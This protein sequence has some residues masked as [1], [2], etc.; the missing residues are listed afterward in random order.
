[1]ADDQKGFGP[2]VADDTA[3]F[4]APVE[5]S[6]LTR[7]GTNPAG[8]PVYHGT[9]TA[10]PTFGSR[11]AESLGVPTSTDDLKNAAISTGMGILYPPLLA[12]QAAQQMWNKTTQPMTP[13]EKADMAVHPVGQVLNQGAKRILEGPLAPVG[14]QVVSNIAE[15]KGNLGAQAGDVVGTIANLLM[16][17]EA[18][19]PKTEGRLAYSTGA[20]A[21]DIMKAAPDL[22]AEASKNGR[23]ADLNGLIEGTIK[24]AKD[25]LNT[26]YANALGPYANQKIM[27]SQVSQRILALITPNMDMTQPGK[28]LKKQIQSAAVEFQKPWTLAQLDQERM[29]ANA[30]L[31]S[32]EKKEAVDQYAATRGNNRTA[33]IDKAIA[34][35]VRADVY[36]LMDQAL[37]KPPGYFANIKDRIGA[38][39]DI[40]S[41]AKAHRDALRTRSLKAEGAPMMERLKLRGLVG[42]EGH[43]RFYFSNLLGPSDPLASAG[44][45]AQAAFPGPGTS[46]ARAA[47]LVEALRRF[48][49]NHPLVQNNEPQQ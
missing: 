45:I 24:N 27:P 3:G 28:V 1:M 41:D 19:G 20:E 35:G 48:A 18:K 47:A 15:D 49:P 42:E 38:L 6:S 23:P 33:A 26:E 36:P 5:D 43:P 25:N 8:F 4:G 2:P 34:D 32:F 44:K 30:R 9:P 22:I 7:V 12:G 14:G 21:R 16:L 13:Q 40:E 29:D 31:H 46:A 39:M 17:K 10:P 11:L 37:G